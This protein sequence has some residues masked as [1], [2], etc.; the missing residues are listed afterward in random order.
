M[1]QTSRVKRGAGIQLRATRVSR[2][3]TR[4]TFTLPGPPFAAGTYRV[5][6]TSNGVTTPVGKLTVNNPQAVLSATGGIAAATFTG[7]TDA[8]AFTANGVVVGVNAPPVSLTLNGTWVEG[9]QAIVESG[10]APPQP[11]PITAGVV[12]LPASLFSSMGAIAV[13]VC[14]LYSTQASD[15]EILIDVVAPAFTSD[16]Y[17]GSGSAKSTVTQLGPSPTPFVIDVV[18]MSPATTWTLAPVSGAGADFTG[19]SSNPPS[20]IGVA[21]DATFSSVQITVNEGPTGKDTVELLLTMTNPGPTPYQAEVTFTLGRRTVTEEARANAGG[22]VGGPVGVDAPAPA[23]ASSIA[24]LE[25][26]IT[27]ILASE[28]DIAEVT[29]E[30]EQ[31]LLSAGWSKQHISAALKNLKGC[32]T[33]ERIG[34]VRRVLE[35]HQPP[36][37][38]HHTHGHGQNHPHT[39]ANKKH[40]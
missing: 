18:G 30:I 31:L 32:R 10:S 25:K 12:A 33:E 21:F 3:R 14:N 16:P 23:A 34:E 22:P 20:G 39:H 4:A 6:F 40:S 13:T 15:N 35:T 7:T 17:T 26:A 37:M 19:N 27:S 36:P 9:A 38:P 8:L 11:F 1:N 2:D 24:V 5:D 29:E 28:N